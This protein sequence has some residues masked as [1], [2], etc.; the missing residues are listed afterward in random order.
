MSCQRPLVELAYAGWW[1]GQ[2]VL[3]AWC[4]PCGEAAGGNSSRAGTRIQPRCAFYK[5]VVRVSPALASNCC[6]CSIVEHAKKAF[7][8][9]CCCYSPRFIERLARRVL[10]DMVLPLGR[11]VVPASG[12][13]L[14][15]SKAPVS[16]LVSITTSPRRMR[17][18]AA[19]ATAHSHASA[20]EEQIYNSRMS[21]KR[22]W[23]HR[24]GHGHAHGHLRWRQRRR[25]GRPGS[26]ARR[27]TPI[28]LP[29]HPAQACFRSDCLPAEP[30]AALPA[31]A[32]CDTRRESRGFADWGRGQDD[33]VS[34]FY[35]TNVSRVP[36]PLPY[37]RAPTAVRKC[38]RYCR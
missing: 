31:P 14:E 18:A 35:R 2:C 38:N 28:P 23:A 21:R 1:I 15:R 8:L 33:P 34:D 19:R 27:S 36:V 7:E 3:W 10:M 37:K 26:S 9:A 29:R 30:R 11:L 5:A 25:V 20:G 6:P 32:R 13:R 4:H 22:I 24:R 17:T 16:A 12:T